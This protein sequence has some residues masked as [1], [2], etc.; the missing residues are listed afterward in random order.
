MEPI[1]Y[2]CIFIHK[3]YHVTLDLLNLSRF[4]RTDLCTG[5]GHD[6]EVFDIAWLF[7][8]N[9]DVMWSYGSQLWIC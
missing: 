6:G 4:V 9:V 3:R 8:L 1:Q 5:R 2:M 7:V